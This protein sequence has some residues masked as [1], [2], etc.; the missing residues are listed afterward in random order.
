M[1]MKKCEKCSTELRDGAKFCEECGTQVISPDGEGAGNISIQD[2]II[3]R[4][5]LKK[6]ID[7]DKSDDE[8]TPEEFVKKSLYSVLGKTIE[9]HVGIDVKNNIEKLGEQSDFASEVQNKFFKLSE[10][11][12]EIEKNLTLELSYLTVYF[13]NTT[14][15]YFKTTVNNITDNILKN[16]SLD[17][18]ERVVL[19]KKILEIINIYR[20]KVYKELKAK[21]GIT[22]ALLPGFEKVLNEIDFKRYKTEF[23]DTLDNWAIDCSRWLSLTKELRDYR[24]MAV[25]AVKLNLE[26]EEILPNL[27][28]SNNGDISVTT[29]GMEMNVKGERM[30]KLINESSDKE[31]EI[32]KEREEISERLFGKPEDYMDFLK[33]EEKEKVNETGATTKKSNKTKW[34]VVIALSIIALSWG[35]WTAIGVF[36]LGSIIISIIGKS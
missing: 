4:N 1:H 19:A 35:I 36:I 9:D 13:D 8:L 25:E 29:S 16:K 31:T 28:I 22:T 32:N 24:N 3:F 17:N 18:E 14:E 2:A 21:D 12:K 30:V 11:G 34:I 33:Q 15:N 6:D 10:L 20:E 7:F 27:I 5:D 26:I 23:G